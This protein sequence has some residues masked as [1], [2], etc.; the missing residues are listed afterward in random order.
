MPVTSSRE[1]TLISGVFS[2]QPAEVSKAYAVTGTICTGA[3][4]MTEGTIVNGFLSERAL[5]AGV[6]RIGHPSGIIE[7]QVA[8]KKEADEFKLKKAIV[9]R[10]ARRIM[11]GYVYLKPWTL[12]ERDDQMKSR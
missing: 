4:A 5:Q 12:G 9:Y 2:G 3:A 7:V 10:T 1:T 8:V 6:V 11:G